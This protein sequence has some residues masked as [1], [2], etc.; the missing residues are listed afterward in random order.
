V[1]ELRAYQHV[2]FYLEDALMTLLLWRGHFPLKIGS[3][4]FLL[5]LHSINA[6]VVAVVLVENP[7]YYPSFCFVCIAW[8]LI[9]VMGWRRNSPDSWGRCYSFVDMLSRLI[10]GESKTSPHDIKPFEGFEEAKVQLET[11]IKRVADAEVK[12]QRDYIETQ[13]AEEERLKDMEEIGDADADISTKVGGGISI[14]PVK[15]ALHPVQ[16]MLGMVC[17]GLR[18]L[19]NVIIWEEAYFSFWIASGSVVLAVACLFVPW[20]F[21]IK[22]TSRI[23]VWLVFGPWMKLLDVFYFSNLK[24]ETDEE[25]DGR[26][27]E[28]RIQRRLATTEAASKARVIREDAA[29]MRDMKKYMFGKFSLKV[30]VIKQDRYFDRPLPESSATPHKEKSMTLAELAMQE[31]GYNRTRLPGQTL[32]GD[33][34]PKVSLVS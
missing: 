28:E 32:V 17:R 16:L 3:K 20:F 21:I 2:L 34:I 18:F 31:A 14:D 24:A 6:F 26:E 19:K 13:K 33:M 22:W 10:I 25:R 15:A 23:I 11:F 5:P 4:E 1:D 29:K 8:V 9:A 27:F 30:P 7:R 12:A